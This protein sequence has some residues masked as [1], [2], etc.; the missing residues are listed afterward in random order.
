[1][2]DELN[3]RDVLWVILS[4]IV[5]L[6]SRCYVISNEYLVCNGIRVISATWGQNSCTIGGNPTLYHGTVSER[7]LILRRNN[8]SVVTSISN[9]CITLIQL[10]RVEHNGVLTRNWL[11]NWWNTV[12]W[13][14]LACARNIWCSRYLIDSVNVIH[15]GD[16]AH[17]IWNRL[18]VY[19]REVNMVGAKDKGSRSTSVFCP[20]DKLISWL[21]S[22]WCCNT[23]STC[24]VLTI[25]R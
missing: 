16:I 4:W 24:W 7:I 12:S 14:M 19:T 6:W 15:I 22:L 17:F 18:I 1:M 20:T 23:C 2:E 3:T 9:F 8:I 21:Y 5:I 10:T 13:D 25:N 11:K